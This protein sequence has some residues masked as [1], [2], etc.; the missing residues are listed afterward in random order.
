MHDV[1]HKLGVAR[2]Q[3]ELV[4]LHV[5]SGVRGRRSDVRQRAV[6][7]PVCGGPVRE[8]LGLH[9]LPEPLHVAGGLSDLVG[10]RV[11]RR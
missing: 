2:R 6:V 11:Q 7:Q 8:L 9:Q 10:L 4:R 3:H 1:P 5:S